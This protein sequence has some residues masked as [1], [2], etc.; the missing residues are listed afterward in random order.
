MK[1]Y[2]GNKFSFSDEA[3]PLMDSMYNYALGLTRNVDDAKDLVQETYLNAYKFYNKYR[4]GSNIQGW[5][6]RIMKNSFINNYRKKKKLPIMVNYS[7]IEPFI[8]KIIL[9]K[10]ITSSDYNNILSNSLSDETN[11]AISSLSDGF[12]TVL[13]LNAVE[14]YSYKE[15]AE[16]MNIPL[17]TVRSRLSR[18]KKAAVKILNNN[19]K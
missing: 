9:N 5:L 15:I 14:N 8:D 16:I 19:K 12:K 10:E 13:V 2:A 3:L 17:G 18:S 7:E 11:R 4:L 1:T 6:Y